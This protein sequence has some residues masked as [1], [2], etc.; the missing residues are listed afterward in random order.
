MDMPRTLPE[1]D[2]FMQNGL[3][4]AKCPHCDKIFTSSDDHMPV[5]IGDEQIVGRR[6][7]SAFLES[8]PELQDKMQKSA[9]CH[10]CRE[11]FDIESHM[12]RQIHKC[13]HFYGEVCINNWFDEQG[14]CPTCRTE[15]FEWDDLDGI[16]EWDWNNVEEPPPTQELLLE[17]RDD[18]WQDFQDR[19]DW[20]IVDFIERLAGSIP[21]SR[22]RAD[23]LEN[24][25]SLTFEAAQD[26]V[27]FE[28]MRYISLPRSPPAGRSY[29]DCSGILAPYSR[30]LRNDPEDWMV[31]VTRP[32]IGFVIL[33]VQM[34]ALTDGGYQ[35]YRS[36]RR[37][38]PL[39]DAHDFSDRISWKT[40]E[41]ARQLY[42][43]KDWL[44]L[45]WLSFLICHDMVN[46][47]VQDHL[48]RFSLR[49][50]HIGRHW[51]GIP[52]SAFVGQ[53]REVSHQFLLQQS[54]LNQELGRYQ[55]MEVGQ[56][57][58]ERVWRSGLE[59]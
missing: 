57:E 18:L 41:R 22:L 9:E 17:M 13:G 26:F 27:R 39:A 20:E 38:F 19:Y 29:E 15:L 25:A 2:E 14:T 35:D 1:H 36:I 8:H 12:P 21:E 52:S 34:V 48:F 55:S 43:H 59:H 46:N 16:V 32:L 53:A 28:V 33:L 49:F 3:G 23:F 5:N 10:I 37:L 6:C 50:A 7:V 56:E 4:W 45:R 30:F 42:S 40:F 11:E 51:S 31:V 54:N 24:P 44:L 47:G 58:I